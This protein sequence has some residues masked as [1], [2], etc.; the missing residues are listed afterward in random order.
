MLKTQPKQLLGSLLL[1]IALPEGSYDLGSW[2]K[3]T[4]KS[5]FASI[6]QISKKVFGE[7]TVSNRTTD[8][9]NCKQLFE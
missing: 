1:D 4:P 2:R 3:T 8:F 5:M 9:K 6:K 7:V